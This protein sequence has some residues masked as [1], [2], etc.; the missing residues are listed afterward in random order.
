MLLI[1]SALLFVA[2]LGGVLFTGAAFI[3]VLLL[4]AVAL[5]AVHATR[6]RRCAEPLFKVNPK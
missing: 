2:W 1:I 5:F 4:N 3:H 6:C